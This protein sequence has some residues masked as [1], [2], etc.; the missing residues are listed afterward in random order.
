MTRWRSAHAHAQ[1]QGACAPPAP[2]APVLP[3]AG[4]L[5]PAADAPSLSGT[6]GELAPAADAPA[7]SD[8]TTAWPRSFLRR[9]SRASGVATSSSESTFPVAW[10]ARHSHAPPRASPIRQ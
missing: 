3:T 7:P 6:A 2:V 5:A 1:P 9:A 8:A 10:V 4:V